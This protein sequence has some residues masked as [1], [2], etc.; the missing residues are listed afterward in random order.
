MTV[1]FVACLGLLALLV[2]GRDTRARLVAA[3]RPP[4]ATASR[5]PA[6]T[7]YGRQR[8]EL[9]SLAAVGVPA[10]L[11][12]ELRS[13]RDLAAALQAVAAEHTHLPEVADRM[14][15]AAAA[16]GSGGDVGSSLVAGAAGNGRSAGTDR[17]G[18]VL[19]VTAA[20]CGSSSGAGLPLAEL[21]DV[22]A[23]AARSSRSLDGMARAELAGA[24]STTVV[25]ALLPLAGMA[26]GELVGASPVATL[27]GTGWGAG[28]L[29]AAL[30]L[31]GSGVFWTRAIT[32]GLRR[33]LP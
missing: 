3:M 4:V 6:R 31:T 10:A 18:V 25:L 13:G 1:G 23:D 19:A 8:R 26:M 7:R 11:A 30:V 20:C 12:L 29:L 17:V 24:R 9:L 2:A 22:A 32:A 16:A 27:L 28:C 15:A 14:R 21:L 5:V 33:S